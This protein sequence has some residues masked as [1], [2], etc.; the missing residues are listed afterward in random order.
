LNNHPLESLITMYLAEKDIT[1][2]TSDLYKAILKHYVAYLN[3]H[4][5]IYAKTNDVVAFQMHELDRGC[6]KRFVYSQISVLK[7]L[8]HYLSFNQKRLGLPVEY[9]VNIIDPIKNK[10]IKNREPKPILTIE[11]AKQLILRTKLSRKYIWHY[12]DHALVYLML[13]TGLR[14]IE[15][16]RARIKDLKIIHQMRVLDVQGKGKT[17]KDAFVK[18]SAGV[19]HAIKDYLSKRKDKNPYLFISHSKHGD[20]PY[21]SRTFFNRMIERVLDDSGLARKKITAHS[22]RHTA[23][24][25]NLLRGSSLEKTRQFLRHE[26]ITSTLIYTHTL[27]E[28]KEDSENLIDEFILKETD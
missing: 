27:D 24:T 2:G 18:L 15:L 14:S 1:K 19:E 25:I 20:T 7:G 5:I 22:L 11:E 8:Y 4:Q 26:D 12:R 10:F 9:T 3:D 23:A 16:R 6:S 13:T 28:L 17:S 21:L